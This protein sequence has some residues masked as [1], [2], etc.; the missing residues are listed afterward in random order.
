M[1]YPADRVNEM[2]LDM[3]CGHRFCRACWSEYLIGKVNGEGESAN[4]QCM[5]TGCGRIVKAGV[6]DT[7]VSSDISKK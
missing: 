2:T 1:D 5:A 7:L 3:G 4:I 6:L